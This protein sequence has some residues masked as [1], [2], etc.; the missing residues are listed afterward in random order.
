MWESGGSFC[1]VVDVP[2][3]GR[4]ALP[5]AAR[6]AAPVDRTERRL[7]GH[8][9]K[10]EIVDFDVRPGVARAR[11]TL[12]AAEPADAEAWEA[13][14]AVDRGFVN[15]LR[16]HDLMH[17]ARSCHGGLGVSVLRQGLLVAAAGAVGSV[18]LGPSVIVRR[19]S[20]LVRQARE[21]FCARDPQYEMWECPIEVTT[22]TG[23]R[24]LHRGQHDLGGYEVFVVH[25]FV[26]GRECVAITLPRVC[27]DCA[28]TLTAPILD[29][30]GALVLRPFGDPKLEREMRLLFALEEARIHFEAGDLDAA[31][32]SGLEALAIDFHN[33][34]VRALLDDIDNRRP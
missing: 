30:P 5:W 7:V 18:P 9:P 4:A 31:E 33:E 19:P 16:P 27:F 25:G 10:V 21:I 28:A 20:E 14:F 29:K 34:Q 3:R 2:E 22:E 11:V 12:T 1:Y 8:A 15:M 26:L 13:S 24:L 32:R 23:T 6:S 17:I